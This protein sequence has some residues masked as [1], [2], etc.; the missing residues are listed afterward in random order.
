MIDNEK[1]LAAILKA[2]DDEGV[3][4]NVVLIGSWCL[5][6]YKEIFESFDPLVRTFDIDFYVPNAKVVK[7]KTNLIK[8]LK[9]INYDLKSDYLTNK[10]TFI[11]PDGFELEFLTKLNRDHFN[12]VAMGDTGVFMES[13]SYVEIFSS[14]YI[15]VSYQGI[16]LKVASPASYVLQKLIINERREEKQEKDIE[17]IKHV[18]GYI[19]SSK[20]SLEELQELYCSLPKKWKKKII[21]VCNKNAISVPFLIK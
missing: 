13:L 1:Q 9:A 15:E 19:C 8:S 4:K 21:N 18:L 17:S 14:N 5:L 7:E 2:L 6:F 10:S 3:L 20:K 12:C 11:S 16:N